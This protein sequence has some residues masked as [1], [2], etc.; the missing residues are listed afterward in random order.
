MLVAVKQSYKLIDEVIREIKIM[1]L[2]ISHPV[3]T[4]RLVIRLQDKWLENDPIIVK[5]L[6][7]LRS[8]LL[9]TLE[10]INYRNGPLNYEWKQSIPITRAAKQ[11]YPILMV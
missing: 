6:T 8:L 7:F 5:L 9:D 10:I 3:M 2:V 4:N 1:F 11:T